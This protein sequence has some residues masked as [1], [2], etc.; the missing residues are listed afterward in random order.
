MAFLIISWV[1]NAK[2]LVFYVNYIIC[3]VC[4]R[5]NSVYIGCYKC[6]VEGKCLCLLWDM[7]LHMKSIYM[8]LWMYL[9]CSVCW[10]SAHFL[11]HVL[12]MWVLWVSQLSY[13]CVVCPLCLIICCLSCHTAGW[14]CSLQLVFHFSPHL[15]CLNKT[16][17]I[18]KALRF[19]HA[20]TLHKVT[21]AAGR[22]NQS[23]KKTPKSQCQNLC[24]PCCSVMWNLQ[25]IHSKNDWAYF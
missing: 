24:N 25:A 1:G 6:K 14:L 21:A 3:K 11:Q 4:K 17:S 9:L 22:C 18:L 13:S 23:L 8:W 16:V 15:A 19:N 5:Y 10:L 20:V 12:C 2:G 7:Y